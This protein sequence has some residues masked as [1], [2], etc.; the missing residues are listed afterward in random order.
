VRLLLVLH[1]VVMPTALQL[2]VA[3]LAGSKFHDFA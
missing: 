3:E 1:A 2:V